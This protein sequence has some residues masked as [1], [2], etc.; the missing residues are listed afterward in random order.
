MKEWCERFLSEIQ[1]DKS[2]LNTALTAVESLM[3]QGVD[4]IGMIVGG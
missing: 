3:A 2:R 1:A 4:A